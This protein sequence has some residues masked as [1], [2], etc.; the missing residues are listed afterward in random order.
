MDWQAR[1]I[2]EFYCVGLAIYTIELADEDRQ[3]LCAHPGMMIEDNVFIFQSFDGTVR[4]ALG[5]FS[6][7]DANELWGAMT[8]YNNETKEPAVY[9]GL[10]ELSQPEP[11]MLIACIFNKCFELHTGDK[12][13][14]TTSVIEQ[15][16]YMPT[17][18]EWYNARLRLFGEGE[19]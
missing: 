12:F 9:V 10:D 3:K 1:N 13:C 6:E 17:G 11:S 4:F 15:D 2:A 19:V 16:Y 5:W 14:G 7:N 18:D 8:V